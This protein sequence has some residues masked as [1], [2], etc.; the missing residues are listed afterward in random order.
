MIT[1]S[2]ALKNDFNRTKIKK[3]LV[4]INLRGFF[5]QKMIVNEVF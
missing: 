4:V 3:Q 1:N 5:R 2:V